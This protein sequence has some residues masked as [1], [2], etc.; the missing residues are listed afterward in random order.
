MTT[1]MQKCKKK[2][3]NFIFVVNNFFCVTLR[4][5]ANSTSEFGKPL[6]FWGPSKLP[7]PL[8]RRCPTSR[9]FSLLCNQTLALVQA[10]VHIQVRLQVLQCQCRYQSQCIG[11]FLFQ[12]KQVIRPNRNCVQLCQKT[13]RKSVE[14]HS[15]KWELLRIVFFSFCHYLCDFQAECAIQ[16]SEG[17]ILP[18]QFDY[19]FFFLS[20]YSLQ[21]DCLPF[22]STRSFASH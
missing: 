10:K 2:K 18:P 19:K 22:F 9:Y 8:T 7:L 15:K 16:E 14:R 17:S 3:K 4:P 11:V 12:Y 20:V 1:K 21:N 5:P 6:I 13:D